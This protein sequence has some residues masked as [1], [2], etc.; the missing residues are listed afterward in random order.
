MPSRRDLIRMTD[1]E[2][3]AYLAGQR[4]IILVT[5][6]ADGMPLP[7]P[8]NFGMDD[9]GRFL[10]SSFRKTQK[11]RNLERDPRA[12]LLVES[13]DHYHE[14]KSVVAW[15]DA[16]IIDDAAQVRALMAVMRR[17]E[18]LSATMGE[19]AA[20]QVEASIAKRVILRFTPYRLISW[21]HA[22]LGDRY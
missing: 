14:L 8:M 7:L 3:S 6:G 17:G 19:Q 20:A 4:R 16:E 15:C 5:N 13:G 9:E 10:I 21:D 12:T 2:V 11:V 1:A 22:K 18:P